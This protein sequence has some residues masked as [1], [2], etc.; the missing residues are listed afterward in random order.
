MFCKRQIA[1][2]NDK[3]ESSRLSLLSVGLVVREGI[4]HDIR[5]LVTL[6][7]VF[8]HKL[9]GVAHSLLV[10]I[11]LL[12]YCLDCGHQRSSW[13]RLCSLRSCL[14]LLIIWISPFVLQYFE[15][16]LREFL[17]V[18]QRLALRTRVSLWL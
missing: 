8:L 10:G 6:A 4:L 2:T 15:H 3:D 16:L 7:R 12:H 17:D 11:L 18:L 1:N 14:S 13:W 9:L 5:N